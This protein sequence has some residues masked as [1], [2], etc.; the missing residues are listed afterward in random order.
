M[1]KAPIKAGSIVIVDDYSYGV[2][3]SLTGVSSRLSPRNRDYKPY[4]VIGVMNLPLPTMCISGMPEAPNNVM[5]VGE[6][7]LLV[8]S[9]L[10]FLRLSDKDWGGTSNAAPPEERI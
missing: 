4:K 9:R 10:R 8:F 6:D 1:D 7:G 3:V 5:L 2:E